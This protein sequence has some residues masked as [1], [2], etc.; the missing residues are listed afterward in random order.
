MG[1]QPLMD[2]IVDYLP[3]PNDRP[4]PLVLDKQGHS[5]NVSTQDS[6]L[7]ALAFKVIMD[8][9]KGSLV[10]TRIYS[11]ICLYRYLY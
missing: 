6:S 1:V 9:S 2:A 11:G 8:E 4:L 3:S 10:F 7:C 5:L